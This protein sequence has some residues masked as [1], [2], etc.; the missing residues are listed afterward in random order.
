[1]NVSRRNTLALLGGAAAAAATTAAQTPQ[2]SPSA[3]LRA[4]RCWPTARGA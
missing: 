3:P 4:R 1:M 2:P